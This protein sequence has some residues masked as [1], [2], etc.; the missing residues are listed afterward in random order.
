MDVN[1]SKA[2]SD[3]KALISGSKKTKPEVNYRFGNNDIKSVRRVSI[4]RSL[5]SLR[6]LVVRS[7]GS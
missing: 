2:K 7:W 6:L 5:V 1:I 4:M 3:S